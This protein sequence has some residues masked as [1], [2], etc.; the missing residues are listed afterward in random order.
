MKIIMK[1]I[2]YSLELR[3]DLNDD[4]SRQ[5]PPETK[6]L[7]GF[8]YFHGGSSSIGGAPV[9]DTGGCGIIA[10]LSPQILKNELLQ[11]LQR[12]AEIMFHGPIE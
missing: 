9:C 8:F 11:N 5:K 7:G 3:S 12:F 1:M 10:R 4:Y 2:L 6:N